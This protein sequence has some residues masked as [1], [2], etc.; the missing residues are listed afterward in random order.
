MSKNVL[1]SRDYNDVNSVLYRGALKNNVLSDE[2]PETEPHWS[3]DVSKMDKDCLETLK[4]DLYAI[5]GLSFDVINGMLMYNKEKGIATKIKNKKEI[6]V[7][8]KIARDYLVGILS[9][10]DKIFV[11]TK[12]DEITAAG[13]ACINLNKNEIDKRQFININPRTAGWG[14]TFLHESMH[15]KAGGSMSDEPNND[16]R[17]EP[18]PIEEKLN[19]V[20]SE[21][22]KQLGFNDK[23]YGKRQT[24]KPINSGSND[25]FPFNDAANMH[26]KTDQ[27]KAL[28]NGGSTNDS[29]YMF[30]KQ[31]R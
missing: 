11:T 17:G 28:F 31:I 22:N 12:T 1:D 21:L 6:E 3:I 20:R 18:G 9:S 23:N 26:N 25:I 14:M 7:G 15:T 4:N 8:S 10:E 30:F 29:K 27:E 13:V 5:T 24:Y 16:D 19:T 2:Q